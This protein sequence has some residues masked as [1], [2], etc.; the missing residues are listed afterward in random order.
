MATPSDLQQRVILAE[1]CETMLQQLAKLSPPQ[2]VSFLARIGP[3]GT[4]IVTKVGSLS[5]P[6]EPA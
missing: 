3:S 4:Q 2:P 6:D 1:F 5:S